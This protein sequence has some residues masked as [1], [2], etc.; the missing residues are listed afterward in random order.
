MLRT[1][2][3]KQFAAISTVPNQSDIICVDTGIVLFKVK[4]ETLPD[5]FNLQCLQKF[6][7]SKLLEKFSLKLFKIFNCVV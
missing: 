2:D 6:F 4:L 7:Q 3:K 1:G 5:F